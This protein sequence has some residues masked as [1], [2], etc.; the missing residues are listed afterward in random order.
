M[1]MNDIFTT[2]TNL[3]G[4]AGL[5]VPFGFSADGLPIGI[6]LTSSHFEEQKILNIAYALESVADVKG[7]V[8][9]VY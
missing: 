7:K 2:S 4:L 3:A 1:Y 6:Q 8:P 5:S 9:H